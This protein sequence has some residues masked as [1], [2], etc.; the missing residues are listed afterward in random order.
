MTR[1]AA[2]E[3]HQPVEI[4]VEV[5]PLATS[6]DLA[7]QVSVPEEFRR[8]AGE[9]AEGITE[10]ADQFRAKLGRILKK[11]ESGDWGVESIELGFN[12]VVKAEAGVVIAKTSAGA[13]F[14]ARLTLKALPDSR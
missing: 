8:R 4:L 3:G 13:T 7:P 11:D 6:G 1:P 9:I 12:I 2:T 14:S 10:I 5:H